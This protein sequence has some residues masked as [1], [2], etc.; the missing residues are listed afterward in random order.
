MRFIGTILVLVVAASCRS[1]VTAADTEDALAKDSTL[2]LEV[3]K[4][5]GDTAPVIGEVDP[6]I[7]LRPTV[8]ESTT[9]STRTAQNRPREAR[10]ITPAPPVASPRATAPP[11][12]VTAAPVA[13][14]VT[15]PASVNPEP[16]RISRTVSSGTTI[17]VSA[18]ERIC[19]N[20]TRVGDRFAARVNQSVRGSG[21]VVIPA[22]SRATGVVTALTG[23]LGEEDL[24][25]DL[26]SVTVDG[27]SYSLDAAVTGI[28]LDRRAGSERCIPEGGNI[29]ARLTSP[30]RINSL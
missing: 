19:V 24:R 5:R 26:R 29:A 6:T 11:A 8:V 3:L 7:D 25:V 17:S 30:L 14:A 9:S 23:S 13:P 18:G 1:D 28:Q 2:E 15:P 27:K 21:G 12:R 22:G 16:R 20:T 4:A 10:S